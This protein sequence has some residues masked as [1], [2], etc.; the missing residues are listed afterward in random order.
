MRAKK[1]ILGTGVVLT[2]LLGTI[3]GFAPSQTQANPYPHLFIGSK[4]NIRYEIAPEAEITAAKCF[5]APW[6]GNDYLHFE[7]EIKNITDKQHRYRARILLDEGPAIAGLFPRK[8]KKGKT[9]QPGKTNKIILPMLY[10]KEPKGFLVM[11]EVFD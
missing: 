6:K 10:T 9:I 8:V 7:I 5:I 3:I 11:V 2:I 1:K 4:A